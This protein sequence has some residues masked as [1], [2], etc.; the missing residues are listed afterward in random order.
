[1]PMGY[2]LLA[3]FFLIPALEI[4]VF[5]AVGDWLGLWPTLAVIFLTAALGAG[6]LRTQGLALLFRARED[7]ERGISPVLEVLE[8][9]GLIVAGFLLMTPGFVTDGLG[10]LLFVPPLR[11]SLVRLALAGW[12]KASGTGSGSA[13]PGGEGPI[14]EGDYQEVP[15]DDNGRP[16]LK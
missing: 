13:G 16:R 4:A 11:R 8:G 5:I 3:L 2:V 7:L 1:M 15:P 12:W 6:L 10:F 9:I 14:I